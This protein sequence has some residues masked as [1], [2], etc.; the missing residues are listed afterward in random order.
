LQVRV[1]RAFPFSDPDRYVGLRDGKDKEIG[2]LDRLDGMD[3]DSRAHLRDELDRRY[4]LPRVLRI[5]DIKEERGGLVTFDVETDRGPRH[6]IVQNPR[7]SVTDLSPTRVLLTDKDGLRYE[8]P[9]IS[10]F[11]GRAA[12]FFERVT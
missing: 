10:Q 11:D 9:D 12:A 2:V 1:A 7:D 8:F 5:V 6:F 4:F 3:A